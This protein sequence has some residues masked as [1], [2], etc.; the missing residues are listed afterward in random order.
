MYTLKIYYFVQIYIQFICKIRTNS[1]SENLV[2]LLLSSVSY[3]VVSVYLRGV[4][5]SLQ[6]KEEVS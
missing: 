5:S 1:D 2:L 3:S 4:D 6:S